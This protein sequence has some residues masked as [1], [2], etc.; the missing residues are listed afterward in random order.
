MYGLLL[1]YNNS[2]LIIPSILL[3]LDRYPDSQLLK[4]M[5]SQ[6]HP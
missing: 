5:L 6:K 2:N 4:T 1:L 3:G